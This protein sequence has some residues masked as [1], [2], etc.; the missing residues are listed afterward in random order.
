MLQQIVLQARKN[1]SQNNRLP[2]LYYIW[3]CVIAFTCI[4]VDERRSIWLRNLRADDRLLNNKQCT[5]LTA[6]VTRTAGSR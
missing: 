6:S 4:R 1:E 2:E 3:Y 5:I